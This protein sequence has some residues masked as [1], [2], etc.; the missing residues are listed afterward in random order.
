MLVNYIQSQIEIFQTNPCLNVGHLDGGMKERERREEGE[1]LGVGRSYSLA[2]LLLSRG[3]EAP[4][5]AVLCSAMQCS[6]LHCSAVNCS[7]VQ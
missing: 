5:C 7:A 6:E 1:G 2:L 3:Q 4:L